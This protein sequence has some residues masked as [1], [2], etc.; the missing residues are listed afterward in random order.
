MY[1]MVYPILCL[2][3]DNIIYESKFFMYNITSIINVYAHAQ[4]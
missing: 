2:S 3:I 1:V 4:W